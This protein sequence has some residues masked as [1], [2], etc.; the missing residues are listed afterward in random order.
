VAEN[1]GYGIFFNGSGNL[2]SGIGASSNGSIGISVVCPSNLYDNTASGNSGGNIVTSGNG[3]ARLG[4][5]P[6]P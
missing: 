4:N 5:S 1:K 2:L 3:C 6:P